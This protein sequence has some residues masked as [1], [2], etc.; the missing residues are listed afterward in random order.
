M[1]VWFP[2]TDFIGHKSKAK[3][4]FFSAETA[5]AQRFVE[6]PFNVAFYSYPF[7]DNY[8]LIVKSADLAVLC[9]WDILKATIISSI[10]IGSE[11]TSLNFTTT[12]S[13]VST[14]TT[15]T[16]VKNKPLKINETLESAGGYH[17]T[18]ISPV[19]DDDHHC[20]FA[21]PDE[22]RRSTLIGRIPSSI[23]PLAVATH[24]SELAALALSTDGKYFATASTTGTI[25]RLWSTDGRLVRESRRGFL[26]A[27]IVHLSFSSCSHFLC[28]T[29]SHNT[30]HVFKVEDSPTEGTEWMLRRATLTVPLPPGAGMLCFVLHGGKSLC[31]A[32]EKGELHLIEIDLEN[33]TSQ[34]R[35]VIDIAK[36]AKLA[37]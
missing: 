20:F 28:A 3:I 32:T 11:I 36:L 8:M 2:G 37:T 34:A 31:A 17:P 13:S 23:T 29:S 5:T 6:F 18:A 19:P 12:F 4:A 15:V 1:C 14:A 27:S 33:G 22:S 24:Q 25:V 30:A 26:S 35:S 16:V 10:N 7:E 21:Y 9:L